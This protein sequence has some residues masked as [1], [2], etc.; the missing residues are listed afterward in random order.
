MSYRFLSSCVGWPRRY[1]DDLNEMIAD[2]REITRRTL[3]K[4]VDLPELK[5]LE[6]AL[7]YAS[8]PMQGMTMAGDWHV[9]YHKSKLRGFTVYYF[10]YSSIEYVFVPKEFK[11]T[12]H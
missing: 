10:R 8:H 5:S 1:V 3:L 11:W 7:S 4:H 12:Q 6:E 9:S 2:A